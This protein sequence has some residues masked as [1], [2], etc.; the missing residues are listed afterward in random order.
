MPKRLTWAGYEFL[1]AVS[2]FLRI[3]KLKPATLPTAAFALFHVV[4]LRA[5]YGTEEAR[6]MLG[7]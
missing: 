6:M 3:S 7:R 5:A 4:S 2:T 1:D